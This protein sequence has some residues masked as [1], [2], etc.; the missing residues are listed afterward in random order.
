MKRPVDAFG[1]P[2]ICARCGGESIEPLSTIGLRW[3]THLDSYQLHGM[4]GRIAEC[5]TLP[6]GYGVAYWE[7]HR[8]SVVIMPIPFNLLMAA[9]RSV[10]WRVRCPPGRSAVWRD[11]EVMGAYEAGVERGKTLG[12]W[13]RFSERERIRREAEAVGWQ[14]AIAR[15]KADI[16]EQFAAARSDI[17]REPFPNPSE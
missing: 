3:K 16:A 13:V 1:H 17:A 14:K 9:W 8:D 10:W 4:R 6:P 5:D 12:A 15:I 2:L 7:W 11:T